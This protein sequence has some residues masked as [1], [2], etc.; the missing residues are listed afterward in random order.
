MSIQLI[1][2]SKK[3]NPFWIAKVTGAGHNTIVESD[4]TIL[5]EGEKLKFRNYGES[6]PAGT[7][8]RVWLGSQFECE[9]LKAYEQRMEKRKAAAEK[10]AQQALLEE[11]KGA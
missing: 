1:P 6:Y 11:G 5:V 9:P 10:R 3:T 7:P 4:G 2:L 8:V